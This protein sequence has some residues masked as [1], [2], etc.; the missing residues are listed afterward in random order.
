MCIDSNQV[1]VLIRIR[2]NNLKVIEE[3]KIRLNMHPII[4]I[5]KEILIFV[6][7]HTFYIFQFYLI[8]CSLRPSNIYKYQFNTTPPQDWPIPQPQDASFTQGEADFFLSFTRPIPDQVMIKMMHSTSFSIC[9]SFRGREQPQFRSSD[10]TKH[11]DTYFWFFWRN[12]KIIILSQQ[13]LL[14]P[15]PDCCR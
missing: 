4:P 6:F 12:I 9:S 10:P 8:L 11:W 15:S 13:C 14:P 3:N 7:I 1:C 5:F 2:W